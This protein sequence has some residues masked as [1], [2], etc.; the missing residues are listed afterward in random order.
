MRIV[1]YV[2]KLDNGQTMNLCGA[3]S[4]QH[5]RE[6]AERILSEKRPKYEGATSVESVRRIKPDPLRGIRA[7]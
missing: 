5:A 4:D 3:R 7:R 1:N 2:A 6:I